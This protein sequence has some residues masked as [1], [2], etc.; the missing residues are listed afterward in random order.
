MVKLLKIPD[1]AAA[2]LV[3]PMTI[4]RAIR[5]GDLEAVRVGRSIRIPEDAFQRFL[6]PV[7]P[8]GEDER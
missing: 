8:R 5:R 4:Y 7:V 3:D 1:A 6:K 2:A